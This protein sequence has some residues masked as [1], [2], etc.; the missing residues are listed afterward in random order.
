[1]PNAFILKS[2]RDGCEEKHLTTVYT[3]WTLTKCQGQVWLVVVSDVVFDGWLL[4]LYLEMQ[5][6][7]IE[8]PRLAQLTGSGSSCDSVR[9][10]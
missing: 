7:L 8:I 2:P 10:C 3:G 6:W 4:Q 5:L 1:M 9:S